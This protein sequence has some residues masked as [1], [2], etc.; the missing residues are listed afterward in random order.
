MRGWRFASRGVRNRGKLLSVCSG[1]GPQKWQ[2][3]SRGKRNRGINFAW[4]RTPLEANLGLLK[5]CSKPVVKEWRFA[6]R[7][8]RNRGLNLAPVA[9][10]S[11][12]KPPFL[13]LGGKG[14]RLRPWNDPPPARRK[15][16]L[17][18]LMILLINPF[19][20]DN[21]RNQKNAISGLGFRVRV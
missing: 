12:S 5:V 11:R 15:K 1:C 10:T 14:G 9:H 17:F 18:L 4:L 21:P 6:S 13:G 20:F 3:A 7:G 2:F 8:V 19:G 16:K